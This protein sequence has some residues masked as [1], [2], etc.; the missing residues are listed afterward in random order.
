MNESVFELGRL[1]LIDDDGH[2]VRL[3]DA[4]NGRPVVLAFL[5]HYG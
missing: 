2:P 3:G 5:R 4:W 1:V